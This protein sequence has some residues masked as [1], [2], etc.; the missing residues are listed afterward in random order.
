MEIEKLAQGLHPLERKTLPAL[1]KETSFEGIVKHSGL[2]EVE[3]MRALQWLE[4]KGCVTIYSESKQLVLLGENGKA[5]KSKGL[6]ERRFLNSIEGKAALASIKKKA[7]ISDEEVSITL[8]ALKKKAAIN[9]EKQGADLIITLTAEGERHKK[10]EFLEEKLLKRH[11]PLDPNELDDSEKFALGEL[12]KRKDILRQEEQKSRTAELTDLGRQ[13]VKMD[14]GAGSIDRLTPAIIKSG[15]WKDKKFRRY[16]VE[17]NVPEVHGGKRHFVNQAINDIKR[18]WL[19]LGFKEM[20]GGM[21][22]TSFWDLDALFVP[23]DHPARDM[24]DTFYIKDPK[25]GKLP[26]EF[27]QKVKETHENGWKTGSLGWRYKWSEDI[28]KE[29]L[30]R[31]H[32]TVLSARTIASLK[33]EDLPAKFFSVKKVYRNETLSWKHL[34]EFI[35]VEGIV[36]DPDANFKNLVGYLKDFFAKLGFPDARVRPGHFPYT[37]PS[38]EV[39]VW[40]PGKKSW[41]ELGGSGIFR[42]ETVQPLLGEPV[43]VLA[44]GLGLE[45][46]ILEYYSLK[47]IREVYSNDLKQLRTKKVWMK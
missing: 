46:S 36:I 38:A 39:D 37:E 45:R 42:P 35:Q 29:N 19:D 40:H 21:V 31:T 5:Y 9:I 17:I 32:T 1:V 16:D 22:Q 20:K 27:M 7:G 23:Q 43:P 18:I 24:Q 6:P 11:F 8:G 4:N 26:K 28:A 14:I 3:A 33:K 10:A 2:K 12:L 34:F 47:D 13:L 41:V 15:E 25:T 30:L 44:W